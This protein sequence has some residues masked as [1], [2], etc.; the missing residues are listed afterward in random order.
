MIEEVFDVSFVGNLQILDFE[1][2]NVNA[3][4]QL[5]YLRRMHRLTEVNFKHNPVSSEF[6]YYQS[7][8]EVA[9]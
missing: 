7:I 8:A 4:D 1:G 5:R 2:N 9:P 6:S 3:V